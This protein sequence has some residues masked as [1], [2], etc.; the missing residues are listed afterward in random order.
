[1]FQVWV[2]VTDA[3]ARSGS[4]KP[5]NQRGEGA[6]M[7]LHLF[8]ISPGREWVVPRNTEKPGQPVEKPEQVPA[9]L[10]SSKNQ[11]NIEVTQWGT[12]QILS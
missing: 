6:G 5:D 2:G 7:E 9:S 12:Y 10:R 8:R 4:C 1:M 11:F 3:Q